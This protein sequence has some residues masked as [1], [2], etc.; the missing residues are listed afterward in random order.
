MSTAGGEIGT[1]NSLHVTR[2]DCRYDNVEV[3]ACSSV[4]FRDS[5]F[6]MFFDRVV[7]FLA[8]VLFIRYLYMYH[9]KKI[10]HERLERRPL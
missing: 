8:K 6:V 2:V 1:S 10:K 7:P 5:V 3:S 9:E 4:R